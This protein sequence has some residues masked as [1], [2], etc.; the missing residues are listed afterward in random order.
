MI[1]LMTEQSSGVIAQLRGLVFYT[2]QGPCLP[3]GLLGSTSFFSPFS[4]VFHF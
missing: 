3:S 1:G 2:Q 4:T